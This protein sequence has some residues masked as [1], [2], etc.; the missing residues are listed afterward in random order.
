MAITASKL[1]HFGGVEGGI[2]GQRAL[3]LDPGMP[4]FGNGWPDRIG[5]FGADAAAFARMRVEPGHAEPRHG[6]A[7]VG[8]QIVRHDTAGGDEKGLADHPLLGR[9]YGEKSVQVYCIGENEL[10]GV[11]SR[12]RMP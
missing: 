10:L 1:R 6:N 12:K 3:D 4:H 7:E 11:L 5:V 9:E 2:G 8:P